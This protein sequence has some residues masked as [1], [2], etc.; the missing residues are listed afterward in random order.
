MEL[1]FKFFRHVKDCLQFWKELFHFVKIILFTG[2]LVYCR[3]LSVVV[4]K[5]CKEKRPYLKNSLF[6]T[7]NKTFWVYVKSS[8]F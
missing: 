4:E 7:T 6:F 5:N 2:D 1:K 8:S 3:D